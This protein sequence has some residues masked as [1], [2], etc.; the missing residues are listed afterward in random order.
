[1]FFVH[2]C[3]LFLFLLLLMRFLHSF[4]KYY[5]NNKLKNIH[6]IRLFNE[7]FVLTINKNIFECIWFGLVLEVQ[8]TTLLNFCIIRIKR[9]E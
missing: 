5:N 2:T 9:N 6:Q 4:L 1:M 8:T 3:T 7:N